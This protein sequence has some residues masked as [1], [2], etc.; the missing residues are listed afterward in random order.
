MS[1][2]DPYLLG[3][4]R[5]EQERLLD[6]F[7]AGEAAAFAVLLTRYQRPIYN[8]ILR[9]VRDTEAAA[10]LMQEVFARLVQRSAEFNHASKFSTWLYAIARNQCID[11][12][13]ASARPQKSGSSKAAKALENSQA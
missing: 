8:F 4:R 9:T 6:R 2:P 12:V 5:A 7:V 10:D 13:V 11:R 3:Y 1:G